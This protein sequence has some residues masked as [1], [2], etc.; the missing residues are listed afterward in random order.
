MN[1][2]DV[3]ITEDDFWLD[4]PFGETGFNQPATFN[5]FFPQSKRNAKQ[6]KLSLFR[7]HIQLD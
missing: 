5:T 2:K 1:L 4:V 6:T 3:V 7:S